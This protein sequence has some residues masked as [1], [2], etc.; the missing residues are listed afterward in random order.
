VATKPKSGASN[1]A[2]KN[3]TPAEQTPAEQPATSDQNA[4]DPG[5]LGN[6]GPQ[7][8]QDAP[9]EETPRMPA[10]QVVH[11]ESGPVYPSDA[12]T[13]VQPEHGYA[14]S[15]TNP[16]YAAAGGR[17][18]AGEDHVGVVGENGKAVK[19]SSL[20][21]DDRPDTGT[22][23]VKETVYEQFTYANSPG[24]TEQRLLLNKGQRV[25]RAQAEK[26]KAALDAKQEP[27]FASQ[28]S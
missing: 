23:A 10:A 22:V 25:P 5:F 6:S 11:A 18:I 24:H 16:A 2:D 9:A 15:S 27:T 3:E 4:G 20:F 12:A 28:R 21:E 13:Q 14:D 7:T 26:I 19:G 17:S 1:G 8:G